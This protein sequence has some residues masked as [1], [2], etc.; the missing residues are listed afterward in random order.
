MLDRETISKQEQ[1]IML[2]EEKILNDSLKLAKMKQKLPL[3]EVNDHL[4][5]TCSGKTSL[6]SLFANNDRLLLIHNMGSHCGYCTLWADGINGILSQLENEVS[7]VL[8]SPDSPDLQRQFALSRGWKF[9]MASDPEKALFKDFGFYKDTG[10]NSGVWPGVS[11]LTLK[12]DKI[13]RQSR[14]TF[15]PNDLYCS[16]WHLLSHWPS[17]KEVHPK[18]NYMNKTNTKE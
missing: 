9:K 7:V 1:E 11:A 14:S 3:V 5:I 8:V 6:K 13:Y 18:I 4:V 12:A 10:E 2:F 17:N 15:G 16:F